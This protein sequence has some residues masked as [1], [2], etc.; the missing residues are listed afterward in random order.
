MADFNPAAFMHAFLQSGTVAAA[1][2]NLGVGSVD[3]TPDLLKPT[4][5]DTQAALDLKATIASVDLKADQVDLDNGLA[6][7]IS[8]LNDDTTPFALTV[9]GALT[10]SGSTLLN[11]S[12]LLNGTSI[13]APNLVTG[14][15]PNSLITLNELPSSILVKTL[16]DLPA[17]VA[18]VITLP[19][20]GTTYTFDVIVD[21]SPNRIEVTGD[22]NCLYGINPFVSG[23]TSNHAGALITSAKSLKIENMILIGSGTH[24][25]SG[26]DLSVE[27]VLFS[28]TS[29]IGFTT[30]VEIE[31][32]ANAL[33]NTCS[34]ISCTDGIKYAGTITNAQLELCSFSAITGTC[35][36]L[37]GCISRAWGIL[38]NVAVLEA[39]STFLNVAVDSGNILV[40]GSGTIVS[41]K[42]DNTLLGTVI[43]GYSPYDARWTVLGNNN[44]TTTDVIAPTGWANY[45]DDVAGNI[46]LNTT[47]AKL[48]INGLGSAT[49]SV[50]LPLAMIEEGEE[51][52]DIAT[53]LITPA[54]LRDSYALRIQVTLASV[55]GNPL[56]LFMD[57]DIGGGAAPITVIASVSKSIRGGGFPQDYLFSFPFF[58]KEA[59]ILNGGQLFFSTDTGTA[60][61]SDRAIFIERISSGVR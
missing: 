21:I 25:F 41:N 11:G 3:D 52:W 22:N 49:D 31:D 55:S 28:K 44:I 16:A 2:S 24:G 53:N 58:C 47:P 50:S 43:T 61:M 23:I 5:N 13:T 36:D 14:G 4:S 40:N 9:G 57:L 20:D 34:F 59:F 60:V 7:K 39:T 45:S 51:L 38:N 46:N 1:R 18:G 8:K 33:I 6:G 42:V 37:N 32:Y 30:G 29:F 10:A 56:R 35:I 27:T 12:V 48:T 19:D 15:N 26:I 54:T 17:P